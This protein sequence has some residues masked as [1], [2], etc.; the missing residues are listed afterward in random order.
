MRYIE[1]FSAADK[2][3]RLIAHDLADLGIDLTWQLCRTEEGTMA[4]KKKIN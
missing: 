1:L 4:V 2:Q 3:E